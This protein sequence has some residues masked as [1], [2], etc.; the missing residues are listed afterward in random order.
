MGHYGLRITKYATDICFSMLLL[1]A[2]KAC[3]VLLDHM[4]DL[5]LLPQGIIVAATLCRR[6][7]NIGYLFAIS[8]GAY[9][10]YDGADTHQLL[11][12]HVPMLTCAEKWAGDQQQHH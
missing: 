5:L 4:F 9:A 7:K 12:D 2:C 10:V 3:A 6:R 11:H 1:H 8:N